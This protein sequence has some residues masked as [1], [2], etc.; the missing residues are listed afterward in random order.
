MAL[1]LL[2]TVVVC[3]AVIII[4]GAIIRLGLFATGNDNAIE[5]MSQLNAL[6]WGL[7]FGMRF[8]KETEKE[9]DKKDGNP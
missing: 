9:Q 3:W 1:K 5:F 7:V 6:F 2:Q 4:T 8:V